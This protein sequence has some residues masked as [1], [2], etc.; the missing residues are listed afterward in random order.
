MYSDVHL[1]E[2]DIRKGK[3]CSFPWLLI[4]WRQIEMRVCGQLYIKKVVKVD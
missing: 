3:N 4:G 2:K 1:S